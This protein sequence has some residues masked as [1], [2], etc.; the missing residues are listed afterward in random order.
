MDDFQPH[1]SG[2]SKYDSFN[3]KII[4][5]KDRTGYA[6]YK[7]YPIEQGALVAGKSTFIIYMIKNFKTNN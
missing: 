5:T 4:S 7:D 6:E 1:K 3:L 2:A